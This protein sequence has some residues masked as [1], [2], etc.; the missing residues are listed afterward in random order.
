ME[1]ATEMVTVTVSKEEW[2][3]L[4]TRVRQL[5]EFAS[6]VAVAMEKMGEHPLLKSFLRKQVKKGNGGNGDN[7]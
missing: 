6:Q 7:S 4:V 1:S 2:D 3:E 5:H